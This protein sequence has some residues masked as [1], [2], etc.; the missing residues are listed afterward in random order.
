MIITHRCST[1]P[2]QIKQII[3]IRNDAVLPFQRYA[4]TL[5]LFNRHFVMLHHCIMEFVTFSGTPEAHIK[6][7][8]ITIFSP[9]YF[10]ANLTKQKS[11]FN[12]WM[13]IFQV[14]FNYWFLTNEILN[15][16]NEFGRNEN[17]EWDV[18]VVCYCTVENTCVVM[19]ATVVQDSESTDWFRQLCNPRQLSR[20]CRPTTVDWIL[21]DC[22][23]N[24][25]K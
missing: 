12:Q 5:S 6:H 14:D 13:D 8:I 24:T 15:Q 7:A 11:S 23:V 20:K 9:F 17:V 22:D 16:F 25:R 2:V 19:T 18:P 10:E 21:L 3:E 1:K 4:F